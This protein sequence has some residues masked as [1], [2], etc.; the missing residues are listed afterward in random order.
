VLDEPPGLTAHADPGRFG[1]MVDNLVLNALRH[2]R[3]PVTV[4]GRA[5]GDEV[6]VTVSDAG[7]G[8]PSEVL[9]RLFE[10]FGTST[11]GTGLGLYI[12]RELALAHGGRV[13]YDVATNTFALRL[14]TEKA[15]S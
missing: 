14:P 8:V 15:E 5:E 13:D 9:P 12:V 7:R 3:S 11:G 1:Q 2:G 10:R 6:V 4:R